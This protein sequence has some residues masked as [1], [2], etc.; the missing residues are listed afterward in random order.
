LFYR[1][2]TPQ[3]FETT[4]G[5]ILA[6]I[7][8]DAL[9]RQ[10]VANM[11][12]TATGAQSGTRSVQTDADGRYRVSGLKPEAVTVSISR[13]RGYRATT[14]TFALNAT[15]TLSADL[16]VDPASAVSGRVIDTDGN[17]VQGS[18]V[19]IRLEIA[20]N[21]VR[22]LGSYHST[23]ADSTGAF[24]LED[25]L[26]SEK[27]I[28]EAEVPT[29]TIAVLPPAGLSSLDSRIGRENLVNTY[30]G[31]ADRADA[32]LSIRL[33]ARQRLDNVVIRLRRAPTTCVTTSIRVQSPQSERFAVDLSLSERFPKNQ[34]SIARGRIN[35]GDRVFVCGLGK[36]SYSLWADG[37]SRNGEA[38]HAGEVL[39]I[40][41]VD[42][43][44]AVPELRLTRARLLSGQVVICDRVSGPRDLSGITVGLDPRDRVMRSREQLRGS[45]DSARQFVIPILCDEAYGVDVE[46]LPPVNP[47][48]AVGGT[49]E[50]GISGKGASI[51]GTA[52]AADGTPI[53]GA[54]VTAFVRSLSLVT[55]RND[56]F[57]RQ[58]ARDGRFRIDGIPPGAYRV[59]AVQDFPY[60]EEGSPSYLIEHANRATDIELSAGDAGSLRLEAERSPR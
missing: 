44:K 47:S 30:Y 5:I 19:N 23:R 29:S 6:G 10:P 46:G 22:A 27:Y 35:T 45:T 31:D 12:L 48:M 1:R 28:L 40:A 59:L 36:G 24:T 15:G 54:R 43:E 49:L 41:D 53:A 18:L 21:G 7:V 42:M 8:T 25:L 60:G 2:Q 37:V 50:V 56:I 39:D 55:R 4:D 51:Q 34:S 33:A 11:N 17:G 26:P 52:V 57:T 14:D 3:L 9:S 20:R 32:A 58:S 38:F 16:T 13:G